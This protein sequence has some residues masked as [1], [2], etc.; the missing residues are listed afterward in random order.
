MAGV[1]PILLL[2]TKEC[3][4]PLLSNTYKKLQNLWKSVWAGA[5]IVFACLFPQ[6]KFREKQNTPLFVNHYL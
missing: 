5:E 2:N 1:K 4:G 3:G 6:N